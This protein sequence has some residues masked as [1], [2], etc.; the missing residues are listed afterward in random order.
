MNNIGPNYPLILETNYRINEIQHE[1]ELANLRKEALHANEK[2][3]PFKHLALSLA[4]LL[5]TTQIH[6][7]TATSDENI[8]PVGK[9]STA[10]VARI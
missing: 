6:T 4:K 10:T 7:A 2:S 8:K 5:K 3:T 1:A 9:R